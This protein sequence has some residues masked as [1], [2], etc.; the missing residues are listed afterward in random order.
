MAF[1]AAVW[2]STND[3]LAPIASEISYL[4]ILPDEVF[5]INNNE[6]E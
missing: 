1:P 6:S 4:A 2:F 5:M 3:Y